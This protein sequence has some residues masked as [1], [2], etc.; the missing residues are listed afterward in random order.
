MGTLPVLVEQP[1]SLEIVNRRRVAGG[2]D[3][4]IPMSVTARNAER[5]RCF[6]ESLSGFPNR[7]DFAQ[8]LHLIGWNDDPVRGQSAHGS[9]HLTLG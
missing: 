2:D 4:P 8:S 1:R 3:A 9:Y 6:I 7:G 5:R